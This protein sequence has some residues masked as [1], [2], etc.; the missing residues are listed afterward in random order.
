MKTAEE[1]FFKQWYKNKYQLNTG[2][3][4]LACIDL[5]QF[6]EA[7][8]EHDKEIVSKIDEM[9]ENKYQHPFLNSADKL[10]AYEIAL[11]GLKQKIMEGL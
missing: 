9:I 1:L 3:L 11:T 7:F 4:H 2:V 8:A 10:Q 5:Q 6:E